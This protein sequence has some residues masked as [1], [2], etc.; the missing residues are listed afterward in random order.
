[1]VLP[2]NSEVLLGSIPMEDMDVLIEPK[3]QTLIVNPETPYFAK[4]PLK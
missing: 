1:M 2:G 3:Q 4:K